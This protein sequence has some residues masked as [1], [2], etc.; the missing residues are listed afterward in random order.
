MWATLKVW[1]VRWL[2]EQALELKNRPENADRPR[3]KHMPRTPRETTARELK[4]MREQLGAMTIEPTS[5]NIRLLS[6]VLEKLA[7]IVEYELMNPPI[8]MNVPT[9]HANAVAEM[10]KRPGAITSVVCGKMV[11]GTDG[12]MTPPA[13]CVRAPGHEGDCEPAPRMTMAEGI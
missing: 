3:E 2:L 9:E 1:F 11:R 12:M 5:E 4:G 10:I 6:D 8:V 7:G 13:T